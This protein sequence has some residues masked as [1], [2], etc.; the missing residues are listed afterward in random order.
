MHEVRA[1]KLAGYGPVIMKKPS[2]AAGLSKM[3]VGQACEWIA[4]TKSKLRKIDIDF[5]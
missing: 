5:A 2:E 4:E 3:S 1:D